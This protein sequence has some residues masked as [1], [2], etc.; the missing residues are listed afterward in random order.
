MK[1]SNWTIAIGLCSMLFACGDREK[2]KQDDVARNANLKITESELS[3]RTGRVVFDDS[4]CNFFQS[5]PKS[6]STAYHCMV[7][8]QNNF[9]DLEKIQLAYSDGTIAKPT[10]IIQS[11]P[12]KDLI[13][14]EVN[15]GPVEF[16]AIEKASEVSPGDTVFLVAFDEDENKLTTTSCLVDSLVDVAGVFVYDCPTK[17]HYSGSAIF[18]ADR[19]VGMHLGYKAKV[20]RRVAYSFSFFDQDD[21]DILE[22]EFNEEGC[23]TRAH[24]RGGFFDGHSRAHSRGCSPADI[25]N[26]IFGK[27]KKSG[28][29]TYVQTQ[30]ALEL[31]A[32][33]YE[34]HRT[35]Q[36][37]LSRRYAEFEECINSA[38]QAR[39]RG[40][41]ENCPVTFSAQ[42][43]GIV[44]E[45][46]VQLEEINKLDFEK[47][48]AE[49][50]AVVDDRH[51]ISRA[52]VT[53]WDNFKSCLDT[54]LRVA[55]DQRAKELKVCY[56]TMRERFATHRAEIALLNVDIWD[57]L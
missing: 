35:L 39:D 42:V 50:L 55:S 48:K 19:V 4:Y 6:V 26:G 36:E 10:K 31:I 3:A 56:T 30:R 29:D 51:Q 33:D 34:T 32:A 45:I 18:F 12:K 38:K 47:L 44:A 27:S 43:D 23:H 1:K 5:G 15:V 14:L 25:W 41:L 11:L 2:N 7:D 37:R 16:F 21:T 13:E 22:V 17:G 54:S 20:D 53:T 46:K 8:D 9:L 40:K 24:V 52:I 28:D 57:V 49:A